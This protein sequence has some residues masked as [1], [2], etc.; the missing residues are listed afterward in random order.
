MRNGNA[1]NWT[2]DYL[3][4]GNRVWLIAL[5]FFIVTSLLVA[6]S[7]YWNVDNIRR[8]K[9]KLAYSEARA[10]WNK[11]AAV[12][13]WATRHGGL[14]V[15]PDARTPP[16]AALAHLKNRDVV[17]TD[18]MKLTL[19]NP[20][21]MMRQITE[22]FEKD[23]G[24]KG[25][26]T[27]KRLLNPVNKPDEW[28]LKALN[29]FE[30]EKIAE[31]SEQTIIDGEPFLRYM[32]PLY[33][34]KGCDM[35][36]GVLGFKEG[37]LRG[38]IS[39]S[40]P[41]T[42]YMNAARESYQGVLATHIVIWL[43]ATAWIII[44]AL[45]VVRLLQ[46]MAHDALHDSLTKL[47]NIT[48]FKD[49]LEQ[50]IQTYQRNPDYL[51]AVCFLDLDRFK[52]LNDSRGHEVGDKLLIELAQRFSEQL[53]PN[54]SIARMGGDEFTFILND[55]KDVN[56]AIA[57]TE[58]LL[59]SLQTPITIGNNESTDKIYMDAS[60]GVCLVDQHYMHADDMIRDADIAMYRAKAAGKA[61]LDVFNPEMREYAVET[62]RIEN[63]LHSA[64]KRKQ[65]ELYYQPVINLP[66][67]RIDGFEGLLRWKHPELGFISPER[68]IP[69]AEHTGLITSIGQWVLE[70]AC[71]QTQEWN[72]R[73]RP[74]K[75]FSVAV[76][77]SG[78]QLAQEDIT[79]TIQTILQSSGFSA[80]NLNVEVTETMLIANKLAAQNA[81]NSLRKMG[82]SI[83]IDDFGKGY[84]SL[85]Y[86]QDFN[87]D[88]LKIDK[89]FVQEISEG[90]KSLQLVI[91][92]VR[93]AEDLKMKA[94]AEGVETQEQLNCLQNMDCPYVQGY[95]YSRPLPASEIDSLL[96]AGFHNDA[97]SL[98]TS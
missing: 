72:N 98:L 83:S 2:D 21:Y 50:A 70:Q 62:M 58:R 88:T 11:D 60:I 26:I 4:G 17:T 84:C 54:D 76:N 39:V 23:Y 10:M 28:Q 63:D 66:N 27:G 15:R 36:H 25:K 61:R 81:I 71:Q 51:F 29:A 19:M 75:E 30:Q 18:G 12:R 20:A 16:N 87:F 5:A 53:R 22:E 41:L 31:I 32:K 43:M 82:I 59:F 14:Y 52:N 46:H 37:D 69:I 73:Y 6:Y 34:I 94:V 24:I 47:P 97:S 85:T 67:N 1:R 90:D 42:P 77:L 48:L 40:V 49:R 79:T 44:F 74:P 65:F 78:I 86:L 7:Y 55:L 68:F 57:I 89:D 80:R 96:K 13:F 95:F 45:L 91:T 9:L 3:R 38:G 92:L 56:E 35:C 33:M 8:E 93:L 64:L